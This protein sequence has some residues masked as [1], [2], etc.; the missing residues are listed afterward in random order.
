MINYF[1]YTSG[2]AFTL[3]GVD[4]NGFVNI[5]DG[6][7]FTGRVKNSFSVELSSKDNFLARSILDKREFD[8]S[9]TAVTTNKVT[10]PEYSPRNVL[11]NDFLRKNFNI[12]YQ[13]NLS[14]FSLSQV[15]NNSYLDTAS[16]KNESTLGGFFGLSSTTIDDR[17]DDNN[18]LKDLVT[19]YHID[20]FKSAS[21]DRFPDLFELDNAK[22]SYIETFDDGFIY[23]IN[24]DTKTIAFSGCF[25]G[26]IEKIRNKEVQDDLTNVKT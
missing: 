4:Y 6:K 26:Q 19:P 7:P 18:T 8:N 12:L 20:T 1:K 2:D 3:S 16:F 17:D 24:T 22:R 21:K 25:S 10:S 9:P 11:S 14:L 15:Y 13:N 23:T 5:I